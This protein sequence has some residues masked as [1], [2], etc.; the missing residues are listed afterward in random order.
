MPSGLTGEEGK[1]RE[2]DIAYGIVS[3]GAPTLIP[4]NLKTPQ[5]PVE[6]TD[7]DGKKK[8]RPLVIQAFAHEVKILPG[9]CD[10]NFDW[11]P[12]LDT[13]KNL[14]MTFVGQYNCPGTCSKQFYAQDSEYI[15]W[16]SS[17][18]ERSCVYSL[19]Y[20]FWFAC[21]EES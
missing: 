10:S 7:A 11:Q 9:L 21:G 15:A 16:D 8:T 18:Q 13:A 17:Q 2:Y 20:R 14:V 1:W 4:G 5:C 19:Y 12:L 6:F 3:G